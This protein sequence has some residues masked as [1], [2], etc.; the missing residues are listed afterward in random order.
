LLYFILPPDL[1]NPQPG[2]GVAGVALNIFS[3]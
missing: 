2:C 3:S 1:A